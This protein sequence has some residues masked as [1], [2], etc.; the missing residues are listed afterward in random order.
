MKRSTKPMRGSPPTH[1]ASRGTYGDSFSTGSTGP[2]RSGECNVPRKRE[3]EG[4]ESSPEESSR[5][6]A[7]DPGSTNFWPS[8]CLCREFVLKSG[9]CENCQ[10]WPINITPRRWC[11]RAHPVDPDG[12]CFTCN[13]IVLTRLEVGNGEWLD[14][15]KVETLL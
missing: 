15:G 14:T 12:L 9:W 10:R 5:P 1:N 13:A 2:S 6:K 7:K 4:L 11:E 3:Q 8:C